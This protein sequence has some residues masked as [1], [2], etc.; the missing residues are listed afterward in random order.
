M[1]GEQHFCE[2]HF[3]GVFVPDNQVL[4]TPGYGW[5]QVTA[6]LTNE[7]SGS[8]RFLS[9]FALFRELWDRDPAARRHPDMIGAIAR[10]WSLRQMSRSVAWCM[11]KGLSPAIEAALV[12][13]E[14]TM[15]ETELLEVC[16]RAADGGELRAM[17]EHALLGSPGYTIR[18]GTSEVLRGIVAKG[19]GAR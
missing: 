7:R 3:E 8:E 15:F 1:D 16:R 9:S 14:G 18:G 12:K 2:L 6:E 5:H 11:E 10:L 4:G 19:S 13:D 17:I